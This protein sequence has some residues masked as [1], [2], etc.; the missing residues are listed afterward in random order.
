MFDHFGVDG[1]EING[2]SAIGEDEVEGDFIY[3]LKD[4]GWVDQSFRVS[5][6]Y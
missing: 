5:L 2:F 6:G 1:L 3:F 4:F